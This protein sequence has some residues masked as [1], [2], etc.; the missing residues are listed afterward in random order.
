MARKPQTFVALF[1][2]HFP[3][4][5][6]PTVACL[7]EFLENNRV[8]GF[9]WGGDDLDNAML[10]PHNKDKVEKTSVSYLDTV[11]RFD[12]NIFTPI[13]KLLPRNAVKVA[14]RGNH[15]DWEDQYI[16]KHPNMKGLESHKL[17]RLK[18]RGWK[19]V[20]CGESYSYGKL[21]F[22]HGEWLGGQ[23]HARKCV[24]TMCESTLYGHF[25]SFQAFTKILPYNKTEKWM[26]MS[27]PIG[28]QV[29]PEW[30]R[31]APNGWV[32]GFVIIEF[33]PDGCFNCYPVITSRGRF[34][35][36]GRIYGSK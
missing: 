18:E 35:Y 23:L 34:S 9:V 14:I 32:N 17:M 30:V 26:A 10:S 5:H 19:V 21:T 16:E 24:D 20:P 1:D 8:D 36:G 25:H 27:A 22:M 28:G 13:E 4:I 2:L 31:N 3:E 11:K 6:E 15:Q 12:E 29:N 33:H 7:Y